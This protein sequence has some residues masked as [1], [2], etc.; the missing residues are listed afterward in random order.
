MTFNPNCSP[1]LQPFIRLL[2]GL[3]V[4]SIMASAIASDAPVNPSTM[5]VPLQFQ[6]INNLTTDGQ[7]IRLRRVYQQVSKQPIVFEAE[8]ATQL[9][10]SN[11]ERRIMAD[12]TR[13]GGYYIE[14]VSELG[15]E[16]ITATPG[17][18]QVRLLAYFPIRGNYNH[19]EQMNDGPRQNIVDSNHEEPE[20]WRWTHGAIYDLPA[21]ENHYYFP[22][23]SAFNG[24]ARLDKVVLVPVKQA[25]SIQAQGPAASPFIT[26]NQGE[27]RTRR[28]RLSRIATWQ[29]NAETKPNGGEISIQYGYQPNGPWH[30]VELG[31]TIQVQSPKPRYIYFHFKLSG[32][33]GQPSP[34]I[35]GLELRIRKEPTKH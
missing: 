30:P 15:F 10:F 32:V 3:V 6:K 12:P 35:Q 26:T 8:E 2:G 20:I 17:Q 34:W 13:S 4:L 27:A 5:R 11:R 24:G 21:G 29:L 19:N 18:Y 16:F 31:K 28:I 7:M 33:Q 23:P 14:H 22:S 1:D 9:V 25:D